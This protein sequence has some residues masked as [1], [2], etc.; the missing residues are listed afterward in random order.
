MSVEV[1]NPS[2]KEVSVVSDTKTTIISSSPDSLQLAYATDTQ[3]LLLWDGT[4][5]RVASIPLQ[6]QEEA[7]DAGYTQDNDK[8]GYGDDY[9][10]NKRAYDFSLGDHTNSPIQGSLRVNSANN[11]VTFEIY[12]RDR[13]YKLIYDLN[14]DNQELQHTPEN[15]DVQVWSGNSVETGLTGQPIIQEYQVDSGAYPVQ[16]II[17]GGTF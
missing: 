6:I 1:V 8:N 2:P 15:Y 10:Q 12:L 16:T 17:D 14:M 11:P 5:W 7:I 3:E 4:N 9:I 13:W